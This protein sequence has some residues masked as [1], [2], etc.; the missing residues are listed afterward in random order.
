[1]PDN[2]EIVLEA[3]LLYDKGEYSDKI[4]K[5]ILDKYS[6]LERFERGFINRLFTGTIERRLSLDFI[7]NNYSSV[8]VN[9]Q[10]PVI[11]NI[12][13]MSVYQLMFMDSVPASAAINEAVKLAK[14]KKFQGLS[15]FVNGVLRKI[16][17]EK[18]SIVLDDLE[19]KYSCP[20]WLCEHFISEC[21]AEKAEE[22][23]ANSIAPRPVII[24]T[25]ISK[26]SPD[27]LVKKLENEGVCVKQVPM[28]DTAFIIEDFDGLSGLN[29]FEDGLFCVQDMSSQIV[30]DTKEKCVEDVIKNASLI[31]DTCAAPGGKTCHVADLLKYYGN[32]ACRVLSRDLTDTKVDKIYDNIERCGFDNVEVQ[33]C[34][35]LEFDESIEGKAD[36]V[37][38]DL[39]CSGLGVIGRKADI[40]YRVTK[41]DLESLANLQKD[42]LKVVSR[43]VKPDGMLIFS[44]CTVNK[45][46]N[47][48]NCE[49]IKENL[50]FTEAT[51]P[52]QILN[53]VP[54]HDG[55]FISRWT[56]KI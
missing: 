14:K 31:V 41:E 35:A 27:D 50:P 29:C 56:R 48:E 5:S 28:L 20:K 30:L 18:D 46:E 49:W 37:I 42:I 40:K 55:F 38:A 4:I 6:Y 25:N 52:Q 43:Y 45:T 53:D 22:I 1:M 34:D 19:A 26:V 33:V 11:R 13:R 47:I 2:R 12:L 23:L 32:D 21:G 44:T 54:E 51:N 24:R 7:I 39:P 16:A 17:K 3:L 10:K 15:G 8:K 36:L 9:K